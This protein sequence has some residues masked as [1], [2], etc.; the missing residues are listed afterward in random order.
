MA[1]KQWSSTAPPGEFRPYVGPEESVA[2]FSL[3]AVIL[4]SLFGVLFGAVSV[5][6]GLA[7]G[8]DGVG[9]HTDRRAFH[10]HPARLRPFHNP[11]KQYRADHRLRGRIRRGRRDFFHA[12][13]DLPG[14]FAERGILADIFPG[15]DGW[16]ARRAVHDP[17]AA[18]I[19]RER[20]REFDFSR[21]HGLR[22]RAGGGRARRIICGARVLGTW[23]GRPVHICDEHAAYV[24]VAAGLSAE[25]A[26]RRLVSREHHFGISGSGLHHRAARFGDAFCG[27]RDFLARDYAGDQIFRLAFGECGAVSLHDS[28]WADD[29]PINFTA[30]T[31]VR[32]AR[33]RWLLRD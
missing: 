18:A 8:V 4:G 30:A 15:V 7:R 20:A 19:D 24:A 13:A 16:M 1:T 9:L 28:H 26:A 10:Q 25:M 5:Y 21:R 11:G 29:A 6:V 12:G 22:G 31:F 23:A 32:L 3:R 14:I 27:R 33:G 2:E 17:A